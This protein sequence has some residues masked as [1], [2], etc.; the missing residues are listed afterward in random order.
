[1][2]DRKFFIL[3]FI[4]LF[5]CIFVTQTFAQQN[6]IKISANENCINNLNLSESQLQ[7]LKDQVSNI[8]QQSVTTKGLDSVTISFKL[9]GNGPIGV[10][11]TVTM[12]ISIFGIPIDITFDVHL[13][14]KKPEG[15]FE[16]PDYKVFP[17]SG[18]TFAWSEAYIDEIKGEDSVVVIVPVIKNNIQIGY[19][20]NLEYADEHPNAYAYMRLEKI[21]AEPQIENSDDFT[22]VLSQ[23]VSDV[24]LNTLRVVEQSNESTKL[25]FDNKTNIFIKFNVYNTSGVIVKNIETNKNNISIMDLPAGVYLIKSTNVPV[26]QTKFTITK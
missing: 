14:V 26:L 17:P 4:L 6:N 23:T 13:A 10:I 24:L 2:K 22:S 1:M 16:E 15:G 8:I 11:M 21:S 25:E 20:V 7:T 3:P 9:G 5:L 12:H 18:T 19:L